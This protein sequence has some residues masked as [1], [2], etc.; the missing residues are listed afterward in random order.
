[1]VNKMDAGLI[2]LT[3]KGKILLLHQDP[4]PPTTVFE[5]KIWCFIEAEKGKNESCEQAI[6]RKVKQETNI[7]LNNVEF[8]STKLHDNQIRYFYHAQLTDKNVNEIK[9]GDGQNL[10]F[11][12]LKE[13]ESLLLTAPTKLF[14]TQHKDLL[15][16]L[17][18]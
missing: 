10:D 6:F 2:A 4:I 14:A 9:R 18:N 1:M 13:L 12:S 15:V 5:Q 17:P 16:K 3:Y 8:I 11:F 7:K